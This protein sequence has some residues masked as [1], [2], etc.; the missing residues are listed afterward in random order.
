MGIF[1]RLFGKGASGHGNKTAQFGG[2][3]TTAEK[4]AWAQA[5]V[6]VQ[7]MTER[8]YRDA[9]AISEQ[10]LARSPRCKEALVVKGG[11]LTLLNRPKEALAC[12]EQALAI[13]PSYE[14][15]SK[16]K[17]MLSTLIRVQSL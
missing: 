14:E 16:Q 13:D 15:A 10:A 7:F 3:R 4:E 17:A 2:Y 9:L 6:G 8:N 1:S 12:Y 11:A 5:M